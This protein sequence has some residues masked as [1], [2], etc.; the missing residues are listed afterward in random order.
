MNADASCFFELILWVPVGYL[1]YH[2][3]FSYCSYFSYDSYIAKIAIII[4]LAVVAVGE[5]GAVHLLFYAA[6][7]DK[8]LFCE[9]NYFSEHSDCLM[10]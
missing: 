5:A 10:N 2:S 3:Y 8:I 1:S 7:L 9:V 4:G 6:V